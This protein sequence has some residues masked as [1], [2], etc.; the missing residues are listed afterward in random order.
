MRSFTIQVLRVV[1]ATII[2][3]AIVGLINILG[4]HPEVWLAFKVAQLYPSVS[5]TSV[6]WTIAGVI[7]LVVY[8]LE[9]RFNLVENIS[10]SKK[11]PLLEASRIAYEKTHESLAERFAEEMGTNPLEWYACALIGQ[12]DIPLFGIK[13]FQKIVRQV[14][15][16]EMSRY[17]IYIRDGTSYLKAY[18]RDEPSYT[19]LC[20][21]KSDL[22]KQIK[23]IKSWG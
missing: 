6:L 22:N 9:V 1:V 4:Y 5:F 16:N 13:P 8:V 14:P 7:A 2:G 18:T 10:F 3:R 11:I 23:E 17:H 15:P 21:N 12:S 20:I 19:S